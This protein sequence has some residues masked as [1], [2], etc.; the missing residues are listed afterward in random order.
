MKFSVGEIVTCYEM[1]GDLKIV[2]S[3]A[4]GL[5]TKSTFHYNASIPVYTVLY[6][7]KNILFEEYQIEKLKK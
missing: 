6:K 7:G 1:H 5:I 2:K 4:V 3:S